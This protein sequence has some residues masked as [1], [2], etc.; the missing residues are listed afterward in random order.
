MKDAPPISRLGYALLGLLAGEAMSGYDIRRLFAETPMGHYSDS[1]GAIYPALARLERD[2]YV[3]GR[4]EGAK[5]LRPRKLYRPTGAGKA[6]LAAWVRERPTRQTIVDDMPGWPLRLAFATGVL[7]N[8]E[9][10]ALFR[11]IEGA[12]AAYV[13]ELEA[14][15]D[16]MPKNAPYP[17]M[18][19]EHGIAGYRATASWAAACLNKL[20]KER[21]K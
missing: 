16:K 11:A 10:A 21:G 3:T 15:L 5:T 1:P 8:V 2:G 19:L 18:A 14:Q 6:A 12:S 13:R 17:R 9:A 20:T 4:V 7:S